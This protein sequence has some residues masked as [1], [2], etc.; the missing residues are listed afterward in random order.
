MHEESVPR[1]TTQQALLM[2]V[3]EDLAEIKAEIKADRAWRIRMEVL[4]DDH[5]DRV[6]SLEK[7]AWST[8][9]L[10]AA[11]S[12]ALTAMVVA[13]VNTNLGV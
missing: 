7:R 3:V 12:A 13:L 8:A 6:R 10:T 2:R 11:A 9:W 4:L 1:S 5:E